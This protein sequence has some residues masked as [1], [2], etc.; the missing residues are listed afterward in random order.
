MAEKNKEYYVSNKELYQAYLDWYKALETNPD[1]PIPR[2]IAECMT[3][4]CTR[5]SYKM[6]FINYPFRED[7]ISNALIDCVK[8]AKKFNPERSNNPF[9]WITQIATNA[10]IRVITTEKTHLYTVAKLVSESS[11]DDLIGHFEDEDVDLQLAFTEFINI[12]ATR[13][14]EYEPVKEKKKRQVLEELN[15][16][17]KITNYGTLTFED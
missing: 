13:L 1:L 9:A 5:V 16:L 14:T 3:K 10:F 15:E 4:I 6:N 2:Y 7:M 8:Y 11:I 12:N 17:N